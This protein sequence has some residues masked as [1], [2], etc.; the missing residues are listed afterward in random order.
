MRVRDQNFEHYD[1]D[2][3]TVT[4]QWGESFNS[5]RT[6]VSTYASFYDRDTVYKDR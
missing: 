4:I 1:P 6:Q 3:H 5:G 2:D